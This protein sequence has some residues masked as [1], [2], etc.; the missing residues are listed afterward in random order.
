VSGSSYLLLGTSATLI[1]IVLFVDV[2]SVPS[3]GNLVM[4]GSGEIAQQD[5][6]PPAPLP[7]PFIVEGLVLPAAGEDRKQTSFA[8]PTKAEISWPSVLTWTFGTGFWLFLL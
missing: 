1:P 2:N 8:R 3:V 5:V 4:V 7:A 6:L